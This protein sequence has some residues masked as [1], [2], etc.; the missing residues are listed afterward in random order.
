M[1]AGKKVQFFF[2]LN[3]ARNLLEEGIKTENSKGWKLNKCKQAAKE[4]DRDQKE[5][6]NFTIK[7]E[8]TVL[9]TAETP[10]PPFHQFTP[11]NAVWNGK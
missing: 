11:S 7:E 10:S 6:L 4:T 9:P 8:R 2:S 1:T 5:G 3:C